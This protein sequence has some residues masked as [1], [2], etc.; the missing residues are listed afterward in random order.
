MLALAVNGLLS[1]SNVPLRMA[2]NLG[3]L[4]L[5]LAFLIGIWATYQKLSGGYVVPGWASLT[6]A[7][8]FLAGIQLL[9]L[10]VIGEYIGRIHD[11]VKNRPLYI[12]QGAHGFGGLG[13]APRTVLSQ[14]FERAPG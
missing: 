12:I 13:A 5:T 8:V 1:F 4:V 9:V 6:V 10:G 3:F 2:L 11:E 14:A 7:V